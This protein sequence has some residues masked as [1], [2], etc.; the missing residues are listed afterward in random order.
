M[1]KKLN[2]K[3]PICGYKKGMVLYKQKF[4]LP[5]NYILPDS[6]DVVACLFCNFVF[7]DVTVNQKIYDKY[8][9]KMA[10]YD[11]AINKSDILRFKKISNIIRNLV[12]NKNTSILDIGSGS[13]GLLIYLKKLGYNNLT[14]LDPSKKLC[15]NLKK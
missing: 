3:C 4:I 5:K 8:Y 10:K 9:A 7:A 2:R 1:K 11:N 14:A 15:H 12:K 13:G 6:Y